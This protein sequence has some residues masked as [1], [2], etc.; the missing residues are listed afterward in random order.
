[1]NKHELKLIKLQKKAQNCIS[2]D[3]AVKILAKEDKVHKKITKMSEGIYR[4]KKC[5][6]SPI[7]YT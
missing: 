6:N 3:K 1:L 4:I 7:G 5:D 2:R